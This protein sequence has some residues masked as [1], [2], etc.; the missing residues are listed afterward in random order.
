[1]PKNGEKGITFNRERTAL[2]KIK[3]MCD[4]LG[5]F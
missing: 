1:M 4:V 3:R 2:A 5:K